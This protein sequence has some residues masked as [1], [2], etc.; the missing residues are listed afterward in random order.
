MEL[1]GMFNGIYCFQYLNIYKIFLF[2]GEENK[3]FVVESYID[4]GLV[5]GKATE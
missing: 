5:L 3:I 4:I 2:F 1:N